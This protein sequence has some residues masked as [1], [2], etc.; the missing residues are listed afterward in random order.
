MKALIQFAKRK[1]PQAARLV[2][3]GGILGLAWMLA[4]HIPRKV[5]LELALGSSHSEVVEVRVVYLQEGEAVHGVALQFPAGAP[6]SVHHAVDLPSGEFEVQT[7]VRRADGR[8]ATGIKILRV[9]TD[10]PVRIS[11]GEPTP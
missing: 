8:S 1:R 10:G 3:L 6:P 5:D 11:L 4:P 2:A 7:E 9:P